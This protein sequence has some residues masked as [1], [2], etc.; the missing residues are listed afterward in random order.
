M[1]KPCI[2]WLIDGLGSGGA[3]NLTLSILKRFD[4]T[5]YHIRVCVIKEKPHS[6]IKAELEKS[7]ISVDMVRM[8]SLRSP[9]N[10]PKLLRYLRLHRPQLIHA[11]LQFSTIFGNIAGVLL[12]IPC[13]S[14]LH[15]V[16]KPT[17]WAA[18]LRNQINWFILRNFCTK[19]IAVSEDTRNFHMNEG[20]IPETKIITIY[21]GIDL[22]IF[23]P[24]NKIENAKK[25][26]KFNLPADAKIIS[27]VAVL[28]K[29]KGI[30]YMIEAMPAIIESAPNCKY[31]IVGDGEYGGAL[32]ELVREK[33]L[34]RHIVFA[35]QQ[36]DISTILAISDL[37]VL[38]TLTEA[39]PTVLIE[40][41]AAGKAIVASKVGGIP[42]MIEDGVNGI[43]IPASSPSDLT[44]A[45]LRLIDD[46]DL[47]NRMAE[48]SLE[49]ANRKFDIQ[50]LIQS[51]NN[52]YD[53]LIR[54]GR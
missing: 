38:P 52:L 5:K 34:D 7:G 31:M 6:P 43:L 46:D 27:T 37:F 10:L 24:S 3:E 30:Q 14:T 35:G 48:K 39:L 32:R 1:K 8:P 23:K 33:E 25:R 29:P 4:K 22:S 50:K 13:I 11:Q 20:K 12:Q 15:T 16:G 49:I 54:N 2:I 45:C 51:L 21:N 26:E 19:I 28:R 40:A 47:R 36:K 9:S 42:E 53:E 44:K 18:Y 41:M 17:K